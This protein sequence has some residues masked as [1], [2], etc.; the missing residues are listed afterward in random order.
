MKPLHPVGPLAAGLIVGFAVGSSFFG[1][2]SKESADVEALR[3]AAESA[4][5]RAERAEL[6]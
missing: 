1:G 3:Q 5:L 2:S 4:R 6:S